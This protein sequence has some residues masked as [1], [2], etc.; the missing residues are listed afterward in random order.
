MKKIFVV[1]DGLDGIGKGE[2]ESAIK[3]YEIK[4]GTKILDLK[5]FWQEHHRHPEVHELE[6]YN[7]II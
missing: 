6:N 3:N 1:I 5:D 7:M 4:K 2:I